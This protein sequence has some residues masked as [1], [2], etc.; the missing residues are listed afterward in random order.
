MKPIK[1][2]PDCPLADAFHPD[3][4]KVSGCY[5]PGAPRPTP[6]PFSLGRARSVPDSRTTRT[7]RR[8]TMGE[9]H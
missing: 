1:H 9:M 3:Y 6:V 8:P 4:A 7:L 5:C 2:N